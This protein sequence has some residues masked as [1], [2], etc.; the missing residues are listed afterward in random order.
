LFG[1]GGAFAPLFKQFLE[2]ALEAELE[3]HLSEESESSEK[4]RKMVK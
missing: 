3:S 1:K 2:A 4:N